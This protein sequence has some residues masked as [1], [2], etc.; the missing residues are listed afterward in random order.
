MAESEHSSSDDN[1]ADSQGEN[2]EESKLE[3]SEDEETL[4]IRMFNLVGERWSLIAGRIPGRT[5]EEIESYWKSR[6]STSE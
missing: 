5:A 2:C 1:F 4:I 6:Y 3:F